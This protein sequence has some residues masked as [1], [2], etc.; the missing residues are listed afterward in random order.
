MKKNA[1]LFAGKENRRIFTPVITTKANKMNTLKRIRGT[2]NKVVTIISTDVRVV[3]GEMKEGRTTIKTYKTKKEFYRFL[4]TVE[5]IE[6]TVTQN[7]KGFLKQAKELGFECEVDENYSSY[8]WEY[9]VYA[10]R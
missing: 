6:L 5:A 3:N 10:S 9:K 2:Y 7:I 8:D 4:A 1:F